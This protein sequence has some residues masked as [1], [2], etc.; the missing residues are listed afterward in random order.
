MSN[1][2]EALEALDIFKRYPSLLPFIG[3]KYQEAESKVLFIGASH[4]LPEKYNGV[5]TLEWY[6]KNLDEYGFDEETIYWIYTR[7]VM[8]Q[9][10]APMYKEFLDVYAEVFE[11]EDA[12]PY[13]A[14]YN[15]F[16][17]PSEKEGQSINVYPKD[18]KIAFSTFLKI[19]EILQPDKIIFVS[20]K[21]HKDF[22]KHTRN[23]SNFEQLSQL[24]ESVPH[25]SSP[26]W[27]WNPKMK[28][29]PKCS[30]LT[31]K[32]NLISIL[33]RLRDNTRGHD[34]EKEMLEEIRLLT[35]YSYDA[36]FSDDEEETYHEIEPTLENS[37]T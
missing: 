19:N 25:P 7:Q 16:L 8:D 21:A 30:C 2:D 29:L 33:Q 31:G 26:H 13:I 12:R 1:Y 27:N 15:Y 37:K 6:N 35:M 14:F 11:V 17:R 24:V 36:L 32:A 18:S 22:C 23:K 5:S 3:E 4:Y 28:K 20:K 10:P 9:Y 34:E